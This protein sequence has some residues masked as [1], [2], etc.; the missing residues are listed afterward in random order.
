[1]EI[2]I[3]NIVKSYL[4]HRVVNG[5][6]LDIKNSEIV[7]LLGPNGAGKTTTFHIIVG[8]VK[9]DSGS[10]FFNSENIINFPVHQRARR[11]IVYLS[12]EASVFRGL[13]VRENI[14]A[15]LEMLSE[16]CD[17]RINSGVSEANEEKCESLLKQLNV[18]HLKDR[19]THN[20][21]GG[22]R[23]RVEIARALAI[24]PKFI[25]LDEP[26]VGI[27]PITVSD[28]QSIISELKKSGIGVVLTDH[29]VRNAL[30]IIDRAYIIYDG[31]ILMEGSARQLLESEEAR[32]IYLG[33]NFKM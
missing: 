13:T 5:V 2:K 19:H 31:K 27:D 17:P 20:L 11:G 8:L 24:N 26:F 18:Y 9:A 3:D 28:I 12:Q 33:E 10:I 23:R 30:E 4:K 32:K 16:N 6:S 29:N 14:M 21:S 25:L 1:M 7:G 22:E 15:V